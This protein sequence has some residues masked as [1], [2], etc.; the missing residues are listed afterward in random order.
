MMRSMKNN[1]LSSFPWPF[2]ILFFNDTSELNTRLDGEINYTE[3][4]YKEVKI[5]KIIFYQ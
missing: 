5:P 2:S 4:L 1:Y 3:R